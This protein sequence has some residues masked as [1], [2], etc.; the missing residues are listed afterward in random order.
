MYFV[1]VIGFT[2]GLIYPYCLWRTY[3]LTEH[4]TCVYGPDALYVVLTDVNLQLM[5]HVFN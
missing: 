2:S 3:F 1:D 5:P 4:N